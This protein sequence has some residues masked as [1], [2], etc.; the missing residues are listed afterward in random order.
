[1]FINDVFKILIKMCYTAKIDFVLLQCSAYFQN[2][3]KMWYG[4]FL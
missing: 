3:T 4:V 1:M 2:K